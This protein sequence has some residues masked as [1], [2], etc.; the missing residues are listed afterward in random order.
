MIPMPHDHVSRSLAR[1]CGEWI[2]VASVDFATTVTRRS[3]IPLLTGEFCLLRLS[4]SVTPIRHPYSRSQA[5]VLPQFEQHRSLHLIARAFQRSQEAWER[6]QHLDRHA[7]VTLCAE[8][9]T[10]C[11]EDTESIWLVGHLSLLGSFLQVA[12]VAGRETAN[13]L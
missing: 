1:V 11:R 13:K 7:G 4:K 9:G 10:V 12:A 5:L 2:R 3:I 8:R 6:R